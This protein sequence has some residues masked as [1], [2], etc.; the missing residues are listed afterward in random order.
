[1]AKTILITGASKGIGRTT[2]KL[3]QER[4]WNV[5]ASMR[6]PDHETELKQLENVLVTQLDVTDTASIH[7]AIESAINRFGAID[8]LLNNAGFAVYGPL[9]AT[10]SASI[11]EQFDINVFG[12]LETTKAVIPH[13]R[14][15]GEGMIINVSSIGGAITFPLGTLY[16][17]TKWAVEGMSEA[18]S[19]ELRE[20][21]IALKIVQ[22]GDVL[23]DIRIDLNI[24]ESQ[25]QYNHLTSTFVDSYAP[26]KA[27]GSAPI[28]VAEVIYTAAT[29]GEDRL[30]YPAGQDS[31]DKIAMR[32][33]IGDEAFLD[34]MRR[35]FQVRRDFSPVADGGGS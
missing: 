28:V 14:R 6:S 33:N 31:I 35:Q 5:V 18:L 32:R 2:A 23:T 13:M 25:T 12:V 3:F 9:E 21:G 34:D 15:R 8:V 7:Q 19:F 30:R 29:D 27:G 24:D 16:H 22:P 20:A 1:M 26:I 4:G 17:G 11:R 10:P